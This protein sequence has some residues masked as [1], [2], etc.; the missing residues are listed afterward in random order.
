MMQLHKLCDNLKKAL[1]S[2]YC[3][4]KLFTSMYHSDKHQS[5]DRVTRQIPPGHTLNSEI[6]RLVPI[7][8]FASIV[9]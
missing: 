2:L 1:H 7:L 6:I 5:L 8:Y 4:Y 9:T 3:N